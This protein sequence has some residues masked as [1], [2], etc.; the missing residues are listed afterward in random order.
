MSA[1]IYNFPEKEQLPGDREELPITEETPSF[2]TWFLVGC[3]L[4][5]FL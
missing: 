3:G 5:L 2:L 4:G 1:I